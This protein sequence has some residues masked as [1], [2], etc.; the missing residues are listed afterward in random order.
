MMTDVDEMVERTLDLWIVDEPPVK[1]TIII[2]DVDDEDVYKYAINALV[3]LNER[4]PANPAIFVNGDV[5]CKF[6]STEENGVMIFSLNVHSLRKIMIASALW[7][8]EYP[9]KQGGS[10]RVMRPAPERLAQYMVNNGEWPGLPTVNGVV[11]APVFASDGTL[12]K[13]KGYN[14]KT[15]LYYAEPIALPKEEFTVESAKTL[16]LDT[17]LGEFPFKDDASRAHAVALMIL[18][19]VRLMIDGSTPIHLV[20]APLQGTGKGLLVKLLTMPSTNGR[21]STIGAG[22]DDEE[23]GKRLVSSLLER[24]SHIM[25][26]NIPQNQ[27]LDSHDLARAVTEPFAGRI[28]G[29]SKNATFGR[30][31]TIWCATGN[32]VQPTAEIARRIVWTRLDANAEHPGQR[33][34]W[35]IPDIEHWA[36]ENRGRIILAILTIV[37]AWIDAGKPTYKGKVK[38]SFEAWVKVMGGILDTMGV[39]GF[40]GNEDELQESTNTSNAAWREFVAAW[41][42]KHGQHPVTTKELFLLASYPDQPAPGEIGHGILEEELGGGKESSRRRVLGRS[43][44]HRKDSVIGGCKI[45]QATPASGLS[46]WA[47]SVVNPNETEGY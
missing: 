7:V 17:M 8:E 26:D 32:N 20:D 40:L 45:V 34:G 30:L 9:T 37:Q 5:L 22:K 16:L 18:P 2:N 23:W 29:K 21:I 44:A 10:K 27:R 39:P 38:G 11:Y 46:R 12:Q 33:D 43:L 24:R 42:E 15:K 25:I 3:A 31:K 41:R 4:D 13:E 36:K 28:L 1:P 35:K 14:P 19:F 47:L 6:T